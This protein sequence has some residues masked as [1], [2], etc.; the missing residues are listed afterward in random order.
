MKWIHALGIVD[1]M[2]PTS[3]NFCYEERLIMTCFTIGTKF[4]ERDKQTYE[5]HTQ[6]SN[7][8]SVSCLA[9][10]HKL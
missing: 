9:Q 5:T 1:I 2:Y 7:S 6:M 10:G 8:T 3:T 4:V